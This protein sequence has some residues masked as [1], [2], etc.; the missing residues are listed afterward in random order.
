KTIRIEW[1]PQGGY[2]AVKHLDPVSAEE[3]NQLSLSSEVAS[4]IDYYFIKGN[5]ADQ[6]I[7]GYRAVTGKA[8]IVPKWAMG[9]WQSRERYR[10]QAELIDVVK[11]YRKRRIPLDNIV[12]D[13]QYWKDPEWGSHEF[14]ESRF[15]DPKGMIDQLHN[16]LHTNLM[17]SVWPKFNVGTDHYN[18]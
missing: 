3:Q 18:E 17:I 12:L 11:Q 8:P 6:V 9:Y 1:I 14:D 5:N 4:Q 13:W 2:L 10:T 15:P 7:S 16:E